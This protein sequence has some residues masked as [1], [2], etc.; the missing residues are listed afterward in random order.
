M[1]KAIYA[2]LNEMPA[3]LSLLA[4]LGEPAPLEGEGFS[5]DLRDDLEG[6]AET[7]RNDNIFRSLKHLTPSHLLDA[8]HFDFFQ[9]SMSDIEGDRATEEGLGF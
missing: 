5:D 8:M 6:S 1:P 7:S 4:L 3:P 2:K 9:L